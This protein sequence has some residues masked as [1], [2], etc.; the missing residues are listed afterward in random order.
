[1][2]NLLVILFAAS[3]AFASCGGDNSVSNAVNEASESASD[4]ASDA[5]N[6][7]GELAS[8]MKDGAKNMADKAGNMAGDMKDG[9]SNMAD[10]AGNMAGDMKD[11]ASN[12]ADK[13][14]NMASDMKDGAKNM[15]GDM[16]A[17]AGK[18]ADDM[19]SSAN[20]MKDKMTGAA[21]DMEMSAKDQLKSTVSAVK[22]A[23][24]ITSLAPSAAIANI[25]GWI[26]TL[27]KMDGT[28]AIVGN[29]TMLKSELGKGSIN[30]AAVGPILMKLADQTKD[31]GKT[32]LTVRTLASALKKGGEALS[33]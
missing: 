13:A 32:N 26:S 6:K 4:M 30:G 22:D 12:M 5:A 3:F 18:M 25:D 33:K 14:G 19:K 28:D 17:G 1:M 8:D 24:G 7:T 20:G 9:A 10:K 29:L 16:K 2:K 15:A 27:G 11:G 31:M 21:G 23:G